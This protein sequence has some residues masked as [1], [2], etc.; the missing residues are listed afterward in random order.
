MRLWRLTNA[1]FEASALLGDGAFQYGGRWNSP[2]NRVIYTAPSVAAATLEVLAHSGSVIDR[3]VA[4]ELEVPTRLLHELDMSGAPRDWQR[5][6]RWCRA[7]GDAWLADALAHAPRGLGLIVP[8]AVLGVEVPERN[9][10]LNVSHPSFASIR[11]R[12]SIDVW[13]DERLGPP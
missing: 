13:L 9:V 12:R 6:E 2:G 7:Q 1:R 8:S 3:Y 10:M 5:R 11:A 4:I